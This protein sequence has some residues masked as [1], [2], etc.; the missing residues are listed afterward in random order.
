MT[1]ARP[2]A[3]LA[4]L[5]RYHLGPTLA[6][7]SSAALAQIGWVGASGTVYEFALPPELL[8]IAE[9]EGYEPLYVNVG[10]WTYRGH[11]RYVIDANKVHKSFADKRRDDA[12]NGDQ[13]QDYP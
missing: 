10:H 4:M 5:D 9:P 12:N 11:G 6:H 2:V 7:N 13:R 8:D 1:D 3:G